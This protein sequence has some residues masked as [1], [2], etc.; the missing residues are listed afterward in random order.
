MKIKIAPFLLL[1]LC[2]VAMAQ[3]IVKFP[4]ENITFSNDSQWIEAEAIVSD[5]VTGDYYGCAAQTP[6]SNTIQSGVEFEQTLSGCNQDKTRTTQYRQQNK[7]T[8][9][10]RNIGNPITETSTESNLTY[11]KN[12]YGTLENETFTIGYGAEAIK[13]GNNR[14]VG[15]YARSNTGVVLGT[16]YMN[17]DNQRVLVYFSSPSTT[18]CRLYFGVA[19]ESGWTPNTTTNLQTALAFV[20]KYKYIDLYNAD[21]SLYKRFDFT[22]AGSTV[23]NDGAYKALIIPCTDMD[24]FYSNPSVY[25]KAIL[26]TF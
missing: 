17:S 2:S 14:F 18:T 11:K 21:N 25:S 20:N 10:Y 12:T 3:Y 16:K 1:P 15:V 23:N 13:Y 26:N 24:P 7:K 9:E 6:E 19:E 4:V 5:W 8:L 22:M